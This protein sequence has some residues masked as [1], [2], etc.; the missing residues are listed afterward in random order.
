MIGSHIIPKFY[1]EQFATP[2]NRG[3]NKPGRL[4]VYQKG[5]K[6]Q[7]RATSV[8]GKENGYFGFIR[9]D[10]SLEESFETVLAGRENEC[11]EV[12]A[13]AKSD[14][15][16][17][18]PGSCDKLAFYAALVHARATQRRDFSERNR[19][20]VITQLR[21]ASSDENLLKEIADALG[22]HFGEPVAVSYIRKGFRNMGGEGAE[23]FGCQEFLRIYS[24][25]SSL[26][27]CCDQPKD[28]S[29]RLRIT[30][31]SHLFPSP[32]GSSTRA[33]D[34]TRRT[35]LRCFR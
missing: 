27:V 30:P 26:G 5:K 14:L 20:N 10:G 1:L 35:Q 2:S 8:Q 21:A 6:P 18:P 22:R 16:H 17:W 31:S 19:K 4:W 12:L 15:F 33:M 23:H 7:Q 32:T 3:E 13:C 29:S 9:P 24:S 11:N 34:S 28:T 25:L